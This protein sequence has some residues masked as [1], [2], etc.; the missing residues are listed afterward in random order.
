MG[1]KFKY[2]EADLI[3]LL[4]ENDKKAF[5][6]LYDNYSPALLGITLKIVK[7]PEV[8]NDVLQ[9]SFLKI[10]KNFQTYDSAK[11]SVFTWMLNVTRNHAIDTLR[12]KK[13]KYETE[14]PEDYLAL[15]NGMSQQANTD[16]LGIKQTLLTALDPSHQEIIDAIYFNGL[17]QEET[18]KE[19][20]IPLG[21]VKTRTRTALRELRKMFKE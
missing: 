18:S 14:M 4:Y 19:L 13:Y 6:Y 5:E 3:K 17:T 16:T 11:S 15:T 10:W 21:T 20:N 12:K 8:A 9:E 2:N 7:D 1:E